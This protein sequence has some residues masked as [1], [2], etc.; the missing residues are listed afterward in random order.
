[1]SANQPGV[2]DHARH[3][4]YSDPGSLA[5]LLDG[6]PADPAALSAALRGLIGHYREE[7]D[8]LDPAH[9]A[10]VDACWVSEILRIDQARH[11]TPLSEARPADQRVQGCCRDHALVAVS[12]LRQ[13]GVPA[14][15]RIGFAGYFL[16]GW[17]VDHVLP[18][19]WDGDRWRMFEPESPTP[20][21][22]LPDPLDVPR[23]PATSRGFVT[24]ATA[25]AAHRAGEIDLDRFGVHPEVPGLRGAG[26][27][28]R[29]VIAEVAHR[30]GDELL[31]WHEWG[32]MGDP[33]APPD[34][35]TAALADDVA[36]SLLA[37]DAGD[38]AAERALLGRYRDDARLHPG[39]VVT[40]YSPVGDGTPVED[41]VG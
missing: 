33:D 23:S 39:P 12:A 18:E 32:A 41:R 30:F 20:L 26:F 9:R 15:T 40:R 16:P 3:S 7:A 27:V 6:L 2:L 13:H 22:G 17:H 25:W 38:H 21:P 1:M 34:A 11:G 8:A 28:S 31:L 37:A 10:D 36:A 4:R 5:G 29:Y 35:D 19:L 14:R 24:A